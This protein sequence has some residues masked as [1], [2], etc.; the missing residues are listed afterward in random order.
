VRFKSD[1]KNRGGVLDRGLWRYSRHPNHFG[2]ACVWWG[3]YLVATE[4]AWGVWTLPAPVVMTYLLARW[5][6]V[7]TVES[8]MRRHPGHTDYAAR[9]PAF[10]P[11]FP[12]P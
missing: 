11:W 8:R 9:T 6:G 4:S 10:V 7:P 3:L 12:K 2:D 1:P 5:S